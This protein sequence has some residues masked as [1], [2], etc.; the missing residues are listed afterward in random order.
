[1][2]EKR[3][4]ENAKYALSHN[5]GLGSAVVIS[6][7]KK[8]NDNFERKEHQTSDPDKLEKIE[9]DFKNGPTQNKLRAK[10]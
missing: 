8:F 5:L 7:L 1:M 3:Q 6:I 2:S 9:K 4:V 10:F